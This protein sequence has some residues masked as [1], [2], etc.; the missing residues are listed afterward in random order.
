MAADITERKQAEQA[1]SAARIK[2]I[3]AQE[4]ERSR[5]ARELHDD[6]SQRLALLTVELDQLRHGTIDLADEVRGRLNELRGDAAEIAADVQHLS[7][8]LHSARLEYLGITAAMKSFCRGF[9][10][11]KGVE[12]DFKAQDIP[13]SLPPEVSLCLFRVLQEALHNSAKHSGAGIFEVRLWGTL[14]DI[15]LTVRDSGVGFDSTAVRENHGIGLIS[16]E[17]RL[18]LVNGTFSVDSQPNLGTTIHARVPLSSVR[19]SLEATG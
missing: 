16:M 3:E 13:R 2:L 8:E 11:K 17:E 6:I 14:D 5:I 1:L 19:D 10:E 4:K 7:H 15:C 18:K 12:V 9:A